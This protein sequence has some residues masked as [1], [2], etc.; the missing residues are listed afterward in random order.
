MKKFWTVFMAALF[1][2][3]TAVV[4]QT[5]TVETTKKKV[6]TEAS[7]IDKKKTEAVTKVNA[8]GDKLKK[9]GT[10][11]K[12]FKENKTAVDNGVKKADAKKADAVSKVNAAGDKLKKDGTVDKRFKENKAAVNTDVKKAQSTAKTEVTNA[13]T[14]SDKYKAKVVNGI[15]VKKD[16]TPDKRYKENKVA[17]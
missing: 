8:A 3:A 5:P 12:R 11:D 2:T 1:L 7:K 16:G 6:R 10:V 15:H 17:K 13:K 4:A 9:D 14:N